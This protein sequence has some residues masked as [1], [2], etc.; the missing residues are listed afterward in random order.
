[1]RIHDTDGNKDV[2]VD[3]VILPDLQLLEDRDFETSCCHFF[4]TIAIIGTVFIRSL[5]INI[6]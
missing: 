3:I 4:V 2:T 1:M 6:F 5:A